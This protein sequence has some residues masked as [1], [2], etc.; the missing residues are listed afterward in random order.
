MLVELGVKA[1]KALPTSLVERANESDGP[2]P[3]E[4]RALLAQVP[5]AATLSS[6]A[7]PDT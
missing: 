3:Q 1:T 7:Q 2:A 4:P 6:P 5:D